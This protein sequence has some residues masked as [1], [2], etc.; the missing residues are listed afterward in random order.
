MMKPPAL[1]RRIGPHIPTPLPSL[2]FALGLEL[3]RHRKWLQPPDELLDRR[4]A[5]HVTDLGLR[6]RFTYT[7][8]G[9][10]PLLGGKEELELSAGTADFLALLRGTAD[11]DTLFFQRK[12]GIR[13]DTELGLIVK[14]WL[15]A[16]ERPAWLQRLVAQD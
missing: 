5:L 13:G 15:D 12:L 8:Q 10:R 6:V 1:L 9:F 7:A 2:P 16:S 4:F 11:A 14:N 3:A